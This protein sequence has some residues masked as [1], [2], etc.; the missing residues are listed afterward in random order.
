MGHVDHGKTSLLDYIR[1]TRVVAGEAG[2]ITQ[3]IGAYQAEYQGKPITFID[4]PGHAAFSKMRSR[5]AAAT[6]IVILVVAADDGVK[7]QTVESIQHIKKSGAPFIVAINKMDAMGASPEMVKAQLT[8]HEV[9]VSGYGGDTEALLL[10][11]KTGE[12][13]DAL[14]ETLVTMGE[15]MELQA[16]PDAPFEGVV[17]E[18]SKDKSRGNLATILVRKGTLTPRTPLFSEN[19]QGTARTLRDAAG[20][21]LE[22]ALPG[23]PVEIAGFEEAPP[24]GAPVTSEPREFI[25]E[26]KAAPKLVFHGLEQ[27]QTK[28]KVILKTD[29]LGSLEAI[30][31]SLGTENVDF[32]GEGVGDVTES[33]VQLAET[34]GSLILAFQVKTPGSIKKL[35]DRAGVI[36]KTYRIIYELLDEMNLRILRLI[37]PDLDEKEIGIVAVKQIFNMRGSVVLG[38]L[39]QSG[40]VRKGETV[41][42]KRGE[43]VVSDAK[44][45]SLKQGKIDVE[46]V[47][48][49]NECGLV[50]DKP[51]SVQAGDVLSVF[52]KISLE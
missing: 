46:L 1:K 40:R 5:G 38:C 9:Y 20:R 12:G 36:I 34:T 35:A 13:V 29:V 41:H 6:D 8:E 51:G 14:L 31:Q 23:T 49:D 27:P 19:V 32:L 22:K 15:L 37:E 17:I 47:E 26:V 44:V 43:K 28:L 11:A 10:S 25:P 18:S 7:P 33:D 30:K 2:G 39:V 42:I 48:K 16:D 24:V 21:T 50:L 4:T 3:H 52:E 45:I